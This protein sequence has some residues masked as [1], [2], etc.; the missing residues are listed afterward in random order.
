MVKRRVLLVVL[1]VLVALAGVIGVLY[2]RE[3]FL[4]L[5]YPLKYEDTIVQCAK[6][7]RLDPYFICALIHAESRFDLDAVSE[8]H[9]QGLM[10]VMPETAEWI[11]EKLDMADYDLKDPETNIRFG[12]WYLHFLEDKFGGDVQLTLAAYNAGHGK[13][14]QWLAEGYA[15]PDGSLR[16]IPYEETKNYVDKV[17]KAYAVYQKLYEIG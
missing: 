17:N 11:A 7:Y 4:K 10:Q 1:V 9:A 8:D 14:D 3:Y 12:C 2:L 15:A 16:E 5:E 6:E 13:V